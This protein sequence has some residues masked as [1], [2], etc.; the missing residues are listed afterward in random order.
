MVNEVGK[1]DLVA[2]RVFGNEFGQTLSHIQSTSLL[3]KENRNP[4]HKFGGR[5]QTE[6]RRR[7]ILNALFKISIPIAFLKQDLTLLRD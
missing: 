5:C 2:L 1:L 6:L 3:F 7:R 4:C